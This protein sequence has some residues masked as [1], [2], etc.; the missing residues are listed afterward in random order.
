MVIALAA[1]FIALSGTAIAA[2]V[3]PLAKRALVADNA[4]KL[5]GQPAAAVVQQAAQLPS[6]ATS[7]AG[8]ITVKSGTWT[9]APGGYST[10]TVSCDSGQRAISYG[11]EDP[12]GYA[13]EW[14]SR[15][16]ADAAS[17][18]LDM[19]VSSNAPGQQSGALYA[20]CLK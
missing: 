4:L 3:V 12:G 5:G 20:I 19:Q 8:L 14:D 11:W 17:W 15:P 1:L 7:A 9:L 6:P 13:H 10:F 18:N 16:S 2:G